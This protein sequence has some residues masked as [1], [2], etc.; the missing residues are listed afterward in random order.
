MRQIGVLKGHREYVQ[1][2]D[3]SLDGKTLASG[4]GRREDYTVRLWDV[5]ARKQIAVLDEHK[6]IVHTV[7]FSPDGKTLASG[8]V[9]FT[10]RL[11]DV[12][13]QQQAA[14]FW[15]HTQPVNKEEMFHASVGE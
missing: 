1:S 5:A 8:S 12:P 3:F 2:V 15:H 4:G 14:V 6:N 11:W 10:V 13:N 7:A 9:D